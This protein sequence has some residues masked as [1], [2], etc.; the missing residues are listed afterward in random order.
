VFLQYLVSLYKGGSNMTR[1]DFWL[2]DYQPDVD[3]KSGNQLKKP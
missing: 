3:E 2:A 1:L